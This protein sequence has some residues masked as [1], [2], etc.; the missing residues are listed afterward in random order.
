[1]AI[2]KWALEI[3]RLLFNIYDNVFRIQSPH[4]YFYG[5]QRNKIKNREIKKIN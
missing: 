3:K 4:E 1:M 2:I 5:K